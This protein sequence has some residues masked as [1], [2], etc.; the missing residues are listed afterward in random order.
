MI[1]VQRNLL[2]VIFCL[3]IWYINFIFHWRIQGGVPGTCAPLSVQFLSFSCSFWQKSLSNTRFFPQTQ[4]LAPPSG[5]SWICHCLRTID[6]RYSY[7]FLVKLVN[8]P[9]G[10]WIFAWNAS[11]N[12]VKFIKFWSVYLW[13]IP[14]TVRAYVMGTGL[15]GIPVPWNP[16]M[17][18]VTLDP[19]LPHGQTWL[20][21]LPCR[22]FV[23]GR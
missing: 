22:N 12:S 5:K 9:F 11:K 15:V 1:L 7:H 21:T 16:I 3:S 10:T 18:M 8:F 6:M 14:C 13:S 23:G 17:V 20:K 2:I 4:G 19:P